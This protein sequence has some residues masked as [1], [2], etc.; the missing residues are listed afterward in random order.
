[1]R[2]CD[3][4]Y[5]AGENRGDIRFWISLG[6]M[7][8]LPAC[9]PG[10]S[11]GKCDGHSPSSSFAMLFAPENEGLVRRTSRWWETNV[12][13]WYRRKPFKLCAR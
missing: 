3:S 11:M 13:A 7:R 2:V 5:P 8:S 4:P 9:N 1:M 12:V 10:Y 6:V